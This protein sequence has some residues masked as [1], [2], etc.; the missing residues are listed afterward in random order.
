MMENQ[1]GIIIGMGEALWDILP[2]GKK[3][4]GAPANF[5]YHMSQFGY[6]SLAVSAIGEDKLGEEIQDN[7]DRKGVRHL[8]ERV[9][10]P[11][12]TVQVTLDAA[13]IPCYE[14]KE[15]VAWDNI[16]FTPNLEKL[17]PQVL[18]VCFGALAQ[19]NGVSALTINRLLDL[20]PEG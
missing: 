17:S 8:L 5:A 19:G 18:A 16:P 15:N 12:G 7:F 13:G 2:E 11:T 10:Y 4:G 9:P 14:I 6:D 3:L 1:N 20:I